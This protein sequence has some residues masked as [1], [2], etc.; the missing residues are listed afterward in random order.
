MIDFKKYLHQ[1]TDVK[2]WVTFAAGT[3]THKVEV[4]EVCA[5]KWGRALVPGCCVCSGHVQLYGKPDWS[6]VPSRELEIRQKVFMNPNTK[7]Y[8]PAAIGQLSDPKRPRLSA[9]SVSCI[10]EA[11]MD[12]SMEVYKTHPVEGVP[13]RN[14]FRLDVVKTGKEEP[15][16]L[17]FFLYNGGLTNCFLCITPK[18]SE[19]NMDLDGGSPW[20]HLEPD[21]G[22][23][24]GEMVIPLDS[25]EVGIEVVY[26]VVT[27]PGSPSQSA[28]LT[29]YGFRQASGRDFPKSIKQCGNMFHDASEARKA[30]DEYRGYVAA[31]A[32][33]RSKRK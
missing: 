16:S 20:D 3:T 13:G 26:R 31:I 29:D 25:M 7:E 2:T 23:K 33:E 8:V 21:V 1:S 9:E 27:R 11:V 28:Q 12:G 30:A 10:V 14:Y 24:F 17:W 4:C 6:F 15:Y 32:K 19:Y 22:K 18:G 5:R